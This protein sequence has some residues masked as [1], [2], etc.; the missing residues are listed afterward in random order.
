LSHQ[1]SYTRAG[2]AGLYLHVFIDDTGAAHHRGKE[3]HERTL[4][5]EAVVATTASILTKNT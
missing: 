5:F 4:F 2:A 3:K 1:N